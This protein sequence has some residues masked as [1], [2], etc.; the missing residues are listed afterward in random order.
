MS[1][2]TDDFLEHHGVIGMKWGVRRS[3]ASKRAAA[4]RESGGGRLK[5]TPAKA[6]KNTKS[7]GPE[8]K[9]RSSSGSKKSFTR[10]VEEKRKKTSPSSTADRKTKPTSNAKKMTDADLK[11]RIDRLNMEKQYREL[12]FPSHSIDGKKIASLIVNRSATAAGTTILTAAS[13]YAAKQIIEGKYGMDVVDGIFAASG[14]K[15]K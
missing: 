6:K 10:E 11:A 3:A 4:K 2:S 9:K 12:K 8:E 7:L 1:K 5:K 13:I 15:K 14:K